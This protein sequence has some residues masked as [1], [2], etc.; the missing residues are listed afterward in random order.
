MFL[1][2]VPLFKKEGE[3][4]ANVY[5]GGPGWG[6]NQ[7]VAKEGRVENNTNGMVQ[8]VN[9]KKKAPWIVAVN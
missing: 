5:K 1:A 9:R 6:D 3:G 8:D 7:S 4:G 2:K